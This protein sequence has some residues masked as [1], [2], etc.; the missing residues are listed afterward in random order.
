MQLS[1]KFLADAVARAKRQCRIILLKDLPKY[2]SRGQVVSVLPGTM[3]HI[4]YPSK[5]AVYYTKENADKH[6]EAIRAYEVV[7]QQ[8]EQRI[9]QRLLEAAQEKAAQE[10]EQETA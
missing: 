1:R 8:R 4:L 6:N 9:A 7:V 5:A 3:R 10:G 2:G